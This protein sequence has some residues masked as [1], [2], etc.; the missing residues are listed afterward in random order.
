MLLN[1]SAPSK[2]K[3]LLGSTLSVVRCAGG[4]N[5][6][7]GAARPMPS[8]RTCGPGFCLFLWRYSKVWALARCLPARLANPLVLRGSSLRCPWTAM[9]SPWV[10]CRHAQETN[11][12]TPDG[13]SPR[14]EDGVSARWTCP[15]LA[16]LHEYCPSLT[17]VLANVR[18]AESHGSGSP[19]KIS[20]VCLS[21]SVEMG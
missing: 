20:T 19:I 11:L 16:C 15:H 6:P 13:S 5:A 17:E 2:D 4:S 14:F 21:T 10:P 9:G 1:D 7:A 8:R 18:P 12:P 3:A